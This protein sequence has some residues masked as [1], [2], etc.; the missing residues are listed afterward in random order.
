[1][2]VSVSRRTD[3]PAFYADWFMRRIRD[4]YCV[5][6]NPFNRN[7]RK[8]LSLRP[9]DVDAFV[10]WT[11]DPRP[12]MPHLP[13]LDERGYRYYFQVTVNGYPDALEPR[14]PPLEQCLD[15]FRALAA[16]LGPEKVV[17]RYDPVV[18]SNRTGVSYH[19]EQY[20]RILEG[21]RTATRRC[22][23]SFADEYRKA[24][25]QFR[26]LAA[27]GIVVQTVPD[28]SQLRTLCT[29][30]SRQAAQNGIRIYSC[31]EKLDLSPYGILPGKCI[32][33]TLLLT[34]FGIRT[35]GA[36]D[37]SQRRECGCV[38]SRD[39]GDYGTCLHGCAYCYAGTLESGL[40]RRQGHDPESPSLCGSVLS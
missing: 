1:M 24:A 26:R 21:L 31:A 37:R 5:T 6:V 8:R 20:A 34:L 32:D 30:M 9:E 23:V 11:K 22:M 2:I 3:I 14:V 17:W 39:I 16:R 28:S 13:E 35:A 36:K 33:D 40:R 18:L 12:L 29:Q 25:A 27:S 19:V 7:Q 38:A 10:F 15:S 4:Q